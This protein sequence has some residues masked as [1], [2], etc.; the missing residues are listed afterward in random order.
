MVPKFG[1]LVILKVPVFVLKENYR[2]KIQEVGLY[3]NMFIEYLREHFDASITVVPESEDPFILTAAASKI[4]ALRA[5]G[6][7]DEADRMEFLDI[8]TAMGK[9]GVFNA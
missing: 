3:G 2:Y 5:E 4:R 7:H 6:R 9:L 8:P 1:L